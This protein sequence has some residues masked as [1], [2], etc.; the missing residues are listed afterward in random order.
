MSTAVTQVEV[1]IPTQTTYLSLIG[2]IGDHLVKELIDFSGDRKRPA[3]P[4]LSN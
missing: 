1:I 2:S 4:I 3:L